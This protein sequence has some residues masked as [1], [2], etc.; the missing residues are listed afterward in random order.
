MKI[1]STNISTG[2]TIANKKGDFKTGIYKTSVIGPIRLGKTDVVGDTVSDRKHH[3]GLDKACYIFSAD[4]YPFWEQKFPDLH[5]T[6]GMFGEN[7]TVEAYNDLTVNIGDTYKVGTATVQVSE[8]RR[9]CKVLGIRFGSPEMIKLFNDS[10]FPGTY[11][12]ILEEGEVQVGDEF[13]LI[14]RVSDVSVSQ[15]YSLF[16]KERNNIN[17]AKKASEIPALAKAT[18]DSIKANFKL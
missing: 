5:W 11:L 13:K 16:S 7:L 10:S 18:K 8:P 9:P 6:N 3:G 17:L 2:T 1:I 4:H 14:K 12:R 15:V